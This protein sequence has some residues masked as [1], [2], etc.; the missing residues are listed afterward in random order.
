[1]KCPLRG[2]EL[3]GSRLMAGGKNGAPSLTASRCPACGKP[4]VSYG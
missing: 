3:E 1:M 2:G 4:M